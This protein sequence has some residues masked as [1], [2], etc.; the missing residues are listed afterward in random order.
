M[1]ET[2]KKRLE[3]ARPARAAY[4]ATIARIAMDDVHAARVVEGRVVRSIALLQTHPELGAPSVLV[5]RR[6]YPVPNTGHSVTY[7]VTR[8]AIQI[9]RWYR[10]RQNAPR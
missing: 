9:L 3:W 6:S 5:G 10:Q 8:D 7:R 1:A 4:E 2:S